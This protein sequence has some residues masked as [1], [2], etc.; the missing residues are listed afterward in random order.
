[1]LLV[2]ACGHVTQK[3]AEQ[4]TVSQ[5][6][7]IAS[8]IDTTLTD[9]L[10]LS[11]IAGKVEHGKER[12]CGRNSNSF[13]TEIPADSTQFTVENWKA[14]DAKGTIP[15]YVEHTEE[16]EV[17]GR[18]KTLVILCGEGYSCHVC[19]GVC[20][21]A[22]FVWED[23]TWKLETWE[24]DIAVLGVVGYPVSQIDIKPI[25][26]H[27]Y[28]II[29]KNGSVWQGF[30]WRFF[31]VVIYDNGIFKE[32][33]EKPI[34]YSSD[35]WSNAENDPFFY[36]AYAYTASIDFAPGT[37]AYRDMIVHYQGTEINE[38]NRKPELLDKAIRF[39]YKDGKYVTTERIPGED[40]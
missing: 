4:P 35:N 24:N 19:P 40:K 15:Y 25:N 27:A 13:Y 17:N 12:G 5:V 37:T 3:P 20:G 39:R 23:K 18:Q 11:I 21:A 6:Q 22:V 38:K 2:Y 26:S 29:L 1:M 34:T 8:K 36:Q 14:L 33:L 16:I 32:V 31:D 7:S 30:S 28:A 9:S 10:I